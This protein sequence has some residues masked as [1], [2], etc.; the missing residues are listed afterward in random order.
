[1]TPVTFPQ[2][3]HIFGK[4]GSW[5]DSQCKPVPA[6]LGQAQ[7]GSVD[8]IPIVVVA[9]QPDAE[10]LAKLNSGEPIF[11]TMCGGLAPHFLSTSFEEAIRPA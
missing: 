1:M 11:L 2:Q 10:A 9:W 5:S 7:G 8:G 4:P 3:T 6:Y